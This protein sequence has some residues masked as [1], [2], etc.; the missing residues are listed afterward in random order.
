M[1]GGIAEFVTDDGE[2]IRVRISGRGPPMVLLHEWASGHA[3]WEPLVAGLDGRFTVYRWDARGHGG[4]PATGDDPPTV[5]RMARDLALLFDHFDLARPIVVGHSM[6]ALVLW[7]YVGQRGCGR[8]AGLCIVDQSPRLVTDAGWTLGIY[9]DWPAARDAAFVAGLRADFVET[10]IRLVALGHNR[11][12]REGFETGA[13]SVQKLRTY[14]GRLDPGPLITAWESLSAA[15]YRP[16]LP[17]IDVPTL[18]VYG[19]E[20]NYYGADTAA[21]VARSIPG[22]RLLVYEGADH[23]PHVACRQRFVTDLL[24]FAIAGR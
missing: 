17:S 2:R 23:S 1:R 6:G 20:S 21:Y 8:L 3:V 16:V 19:S 18:L 12:A 10:V 5:G 14:L 24:R 13:A 9:G 15:D 7:D 22:A 11:R 4:H